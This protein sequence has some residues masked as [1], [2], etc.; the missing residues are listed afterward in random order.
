MAEKKFGVRELNVINPTGTPTIESTSDLNIN[1]TTT[2]IQ[3]DVT[4]GGKIG[5]GGANYGSSG[6]V[7][8]SNGTSSDPTWQTSSGGFVTGMIM[9]F[10]GTTAPTGW[11]LCDT[12]T[13]AQ[14][15]N[16][17]DLRDK[18]IVGAT[19]GG[20]TTYPGVG[21]G[22]TG[23]S[24]NATL[25]S[26][27]HGSGTLGGSTN[28]KGGQS[29]FN[30]SSPS[31]SVSNLSGDSILSSINSNQGEETDFNNGDILQIDTR[32]TH[33][34]DVHSGSTSNEGDSATNANLPPYYALAFIMKT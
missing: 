18:F 8:T 7:L 25:V 34:V 12:S 31:L 16:A 20:D 27:S 15:A 30:P 9:M 3:N 22:S 10:S 5:L 13:E 23:G 11:V 19:I 21:V 29:R 28:Q 33:T 14:A 1:A 24:A 2:A 26:H 32:H 4:I 17:P 6:Q